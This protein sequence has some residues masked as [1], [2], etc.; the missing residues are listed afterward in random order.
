MYSSLVQQ[1]LIFILLKYG[2]VFTMK[3][4]R[5]AIICYFCTLFGC[6]KAVLLLVF[7]MFCWPNAT[8]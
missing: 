7:L 1:V 6:Y 3:T 5:Q 8:E 4:E 2:K